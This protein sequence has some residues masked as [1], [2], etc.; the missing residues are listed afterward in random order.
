MAVPLA[1]TVVPLL[2]TKVPEEEAWEVPLPI[3]VLLEGTVELAQLVELFQVVELFHAVELETPVELPQVVEL[4]TLAADA[5]AMV[6]R[7]ESF[8]FCFFSDGENE[9]AGRLLYFRS[10]KQFGKANEAQMTP[11]K[12]VR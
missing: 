10:R 5:D 9:E 2:E 3:V 7:R 12:N 4:E 1:P 11:R 6:A 8:I